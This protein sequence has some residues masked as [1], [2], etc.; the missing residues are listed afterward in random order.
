MKNNFKK[1]Q[2]AS[3]AHS[4][5]TLKERLYWLSTL[6]KLILENEDSIVEAINEDY[7]GRANFET[8]IAE[9]YPSIKAINYTK[10]HL[11][12]WMRPQKRSTSIWFQPATSKIV[13]QPLGVIGII[14]PW[15]YPLTL[16]TGPLVNAFAAGN[17]VFLKMSEFSPVF[18]KLFEKLISEYFSDEVI[19]VVN[20]G[21]EAGIEFSNL[22][23]DHLLFTGSSQIGKKV[24]AAASKNLTPVTLEL[25]G[26]SP[27]IIDEKFSIKTAAERVMFGKL[28]NSGQ[29][30]L[31]PDYVFVPE[32]KLENFIDACKEVSTKLYPNWSCKDFTAI[33]SEKQFIRK[34][35]MLQ[36]AID[37]GA[38]IVYLNNESLDKTDGRKMAPAIIKQTSTDM[39]FRQEEIFGPFLPV[40]TYKNI[41]E[42]IEYVNENPRPLAIYLFSHNSKVIESILANTN[43]GGV[44]INDVVLHI[45]QESL[46]FGGVGN[47][48]M[49][50]Y[51]GYE[52]FL[53]FSHARSVFHQSRFALTKMMYPPYSKLAHLVYKLMRGR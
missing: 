38:E 35:A 1:L 2:A 40:V 18:G 39:M 19:S 6:K 5:P 20:G 13:Y 31:A 43:S 11:S 36:D 37:K 16:S 15:N 3:R 17:R 53:T 29:T 10:K 12:K 27:V 34:E 50:N 44:T 42:T 46:P 32:N 23:F 24:M 28:L 49:G 51:H 9:I 47:S 8:K 52:G 14:T 45:S 48:G 4:F 7:S 21:V 30:C 26:K 33:N 22:P 25:G 41:S